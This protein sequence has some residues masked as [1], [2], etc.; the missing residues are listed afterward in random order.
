MTEAK[1]LQELTAV[2]QQTLGLSDTVIT[3]QTTAKDVAEWDSLSH[4]EIIANAEAH[5]KVSLTLQE[6]QS[7]KNVGDFVRLLGRKLIQ[8]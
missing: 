4:L 3:S 2:I 8:P 6:I 7:M 5:F 1:I